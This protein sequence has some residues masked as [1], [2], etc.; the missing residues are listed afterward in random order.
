MK[1]A[2]LAL[3]LVWL[4][5]GCSAF[6]PAFVRT[7]VTIAMDLDDSLLSRSMAEESELESS[8]EEVEGGLF[9]PKQFR[10]E[11]TEWVDN[12]A[13]ANTSS[14]SLSPWAAAFVAYPVTLL[15]ND[16]FHFLPGSSA[17]N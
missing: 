13:M 10:D 7:S 16:F 11:S 15:L 5:H 3:T 12:R 6:T 17:G 1:T 14:S 4:L 9:T 2:G 8:S